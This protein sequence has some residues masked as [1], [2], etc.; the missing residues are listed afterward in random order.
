MITKRL[1][2]IQEQESH[3]SSVL[4]LLLN[5]QKQTQ[6]ALDNLVSAIERGI[7]SNATNKRLQELENHLVELEKQII[8]EKSKEA[9]KITEKE[10]RE[11]YEKSLKLE[12]LMLINYL[13][14]EI[15]VYEDTIHIIYKSPLIISPDESQ[16]FSFYQEKANFSANTEIYND[17][18]I[19]IQLI[20]T[21]R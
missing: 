2:A 10:I 9:S 6:N 13:I 20:M 1:L 16:G 14:R 4:S 5:E 3:T 12:P 7:V 11:F 19:S 18:S 21:V 8:I 17:I 15:V